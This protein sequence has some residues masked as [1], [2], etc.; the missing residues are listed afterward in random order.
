[1]TYAL[2]A[3]VR[4]LATRFGQDVNALG[5]QVGAAEQFAALA[6]QKATPFQ[7]RAAAEAATI[8]GSLTVVSIAG[9]LMREFAG[10]IADAA[11]VSAN[12]R[13]FM[14]VAAPS[15]FDFGAI[16]DGM[17][18][19]TEAMRKMHNWCNSI[20]V[21]PDFSRVRSFA[22]QANAQIVINTPVDFNGAAILVLNGIVPLPSWN[23]D[24]SRVYVV[25]D[26]E[27]PVI[28]GDVAVNGLQDFSSGSYTTSRGLIPSAGWLGYQ[29]SAG[30]G[31]PLMSDRDSIGTIPWRCCHKVYDNITTQYPLNINAIGLTEVF[32][33]Y[34]LNSYGPITIRNFAVDVSRFNEQIIFDIQ[35][36]EVDIE[37]YRLFAGGEM[38]ARMV[39]EIVRPF[40]CAD[41]T[42]TK[43]SG[44]P[45]SRTTSSYVFSP[46]W[47]ANF[48][49]EGADF[50]QE[51]GSTWWWMAARWCNGMNYGPGFY[52]RIDIHSYSLNLFVEPGAKLVSRGVMIG[53]GGGLLVV[54]GATFFQTFSGWGL[55]NARDDYGCGSWDGEIIVRNPTIVSAFLGNPLGA[56]VVNLPNV[57]NAAIPLSLPRVVSVTD[58]VVSRPTND[59]TPMI[60]TPFVLGQNPT[61]AGVNAPASIIM[62]GVQCATR[63]SLHNFLDLANMLSPPTFNTDG[64]DVRISNAGPTHR[65]ADYP[66]IKVPAI[67]AANRVNFQVHYTTRDVDLLVCDIAQATQGSS[68]GPGS[69]M[70]VNGGS[71]CRVVSPTGL[72]IHYGD[73]DFRDPLLVGAETHAPLCAVKASDERYSTISGGRIFGAFNLANFH[74]IGGLA[75]RSGLAANFPAGV[76]REQL[77][78]GWMAQ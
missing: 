33:E 31:L 21:A 24:E 20:R 35:R 4:R 67:A 43:P 70:R 68:G 57:G 61:S 72:A 34:R 15:P 56:V 41:I 1:M 44:R 71:V 73:V 66:T 50:R 76:T 19:D 59:Q 8:T 58:L 38:P 27:C 23:N 14:P 45:P 3:N 18:D 75:S 54:D 40:K 69:Y 2:D 16:C 30:T 26:P 74:A 52:D 29:F 42:I 64:V 47:V 48:R 53:H 77:F 39:V 46:T 22:I 60:I 5:R 55:V 28:A 32:R 36:N 49:T 62:D 63:W 37:D 11:V 6:D 10:D 25:E 51:G 13:A 9:K 78:T 65:N 12:G 7:S 17:T